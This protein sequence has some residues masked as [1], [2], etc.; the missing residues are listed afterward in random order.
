MDIFLLLR[1]SFVHPL[2]TDLSWGDSISQ[3]S[4]NQGTLCLTII[5]GRRSEYCGIIVEGIIP[6]YSLSLRRTIVLV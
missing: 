1:N 2:F 4:D 3:F 5:R 6:Q